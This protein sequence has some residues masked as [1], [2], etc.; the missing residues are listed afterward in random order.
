[1]YIARKLIPL[2]VQERRDMGGAFIVPSRIVQEGTAEIV[3]GSQKI[4]IYER[5]RI[6]WS[7]MKYSVIIAYREIMRWPEDL[8]RAKD[9]NNCLP[10]YGTCK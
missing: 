5:G 7:L 3:R 9:A 4:R 10:K 6:L 2:A 8:I 1:M